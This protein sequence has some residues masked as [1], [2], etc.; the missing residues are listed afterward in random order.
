M[1]EFR[2]KMTTMVFMLYMVDA[3]SSVLRI[4]LL[5][6]VT[7][8]IMELISMIWKRD[9]IRPHQRCQ[10]EKKSLIVIIGISMWVC[11]QYNFLTSAILQIVQCIGA[12]FHIF[13][14]W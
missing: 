14:V 2:T 7:A 10:D 1:T 4:V 13:V 9:I 8:V 12:V 5:L 11:G 6:Q 3:V